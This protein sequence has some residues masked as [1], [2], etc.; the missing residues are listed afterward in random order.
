VNAQSEAGLPPGSAG[1]AQSN[2]RRWLTFAAAVFPASLYVGTQT[3]ANAVLPQMQGDLS[4]GLDQISWVI[5][6]SVVAS[7]IAIPPTAWLS[8]R[9]GR[10]R[11]MVT[12]MLLFSAMSMMVATADSLGGVV[13]WRVASAVSAAPM[14]ALSQSVTLD[15]FAENQRGKAF[16]FWAIGI[17]SGWVFAPALGAYVAEAHSW[18]LIFVLLGPLGLLGALSASV[19]DETSRNPDLRFDWFA[20]FALSVALGSLLLVLNRGQRLDWFNSA[21]IILFTALGAIAL[22]VFVVHTLSSSNPFLNFRIFLDRNYAIGLVIVSSYAGL[23]LAPLVLIPT[24]LEELR[25]LELL[26][27]GLVLIPRGFAQIVGLLIIGA[28]VHKADPRVFV[29]GGFL[30]FSVASV[31]MSGFNLDV[32]IFDVVW[33]NMLQGFSMAF[34]WAPAANLIYAN[35]PMKMRTDATTF[36]SLVYSLSS[37]VGVSLS[38]TLLGRTFQRSHEELGARV[39]P[40]NEALSLSDWS[41]TWDLTDAA[42]LAMIKA[43]VTQQALMIGY[44]NVFWA[45]G[46]YALVVLPFALFLRTGR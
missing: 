32:G 14:V 41:V 1:E 43:E 21:E 26:T 37:S 24:M 18:R 25:G 4:V 36:T 15:T 35:L 9:F 10:R 20:F 28:F 44:V 23:S 3:V 11:L 2:L 34:I 29:V 38:V 39:V 5:T 27:T 46:L 16:A 12:C 8:A 33:P 17:L 30:L 19:P 40:G 13:F 22:Y 6:A 42:S 31:Q 45:T 7:A